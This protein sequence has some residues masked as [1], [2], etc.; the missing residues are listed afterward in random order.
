[1][2]R[3]SS[4]IPWIAALGLAPAAHADPTGEPPSAERAQLSTAQWFAL[5][6]AARAR[7]DI[8][9]A[10]SAYRVLEGDPAPYIRNEARFRLG[11]MYAALARLAEAASLFRQILDVQPDA[12]RVRLELARVL[13]RLGDESGAP[14]ALREAQGGGLPPD[15]ARVVDQYSAALRAQKPFGA[16]LELAIAPDSNIN[17]AT[18]SDTLGTTLGDFKLSEDARQRSGIGFALR[19]QAY[20]R[21]PTGSRVNLLA[22]LSGAAE[23]Y[24]RGAF[25]DISLG[26][27][28]GPEFRLGADRLT[29]E[30][31]VTWRWFGGAPYSTTP[32]LALDY[33]HPLS[34]QAQLRA[35]A[36]FGLINNQRNSLQD[37][38][39]YALS[40]S[41]ER[42]LSAGSGIGV[43][44]AGDRLTLR[45]P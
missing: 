6:E 34:R 3:L 39:S 30:G 27:S 22:R 44:L 19:G 10:E 23:L 24:G 38:Q 31:G 29:G 2:A 9:V 5:A 8:K 41:Y 15:V 17:R 1:M 13:D 32:N 18:R 7:G 42:A 16:S 4:L 28:G 25:N 14:R 26:V 40:M 37:G 33:L 20:G 43:T 45:D 21:T 36:A 12:Q 11:L 35:T